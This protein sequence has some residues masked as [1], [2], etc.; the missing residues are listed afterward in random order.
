MKQAFNSIFYSFPSQLTLL[1]FK[2]FQVLLVFWF[3]IFGSV[4]GSFMPMYGINSLYLAPEYL[5]EV[6][7]LSAFIVGVSLGIFIMSWNITTFI[8]FCRHFKFLA[9]TTNPFL[10]YCINNAVIPLAFLVFYF[11]QAVNFGRFKEL[12]SAWEI[13]VLTSGFLC[14]LLLSVLTSLFYFFRADKTINRRMVTRK[15]G[16]ENHNAIDQSYIASSKNGS[17]LIKVKYYFNSPLSIKHVREVGH[18]SSAFIDKV[19][20]RHHFAAVISIFAAFIFLIMIGFSLDRHMFQLPAGASI[21]IFFAIL[22]AVAGAFSYFL[23]SWSV[24]FLVMLFVLLNFLYKYE[25]IDPT[26]KAYGLNYS[27]R[28]HRP[29][30]NRE[31]LMELCSPEHVKKDEEGMLEVLEN[32]RLK[33]NVEKPV[34]YLIA[35]SGGGTRSATFTLNTLQYLDSLCMGKLM[36]KTFMITGSSGGML[37]AAYFRALAQQKSQG[38]DINLSDNKYVDNISGDLL[39]PMLSSFVARDM[40]SPAQKFKAGNYY[41][42]KDR[43][44]AFEQKLAENTQWLLNKQLKDLAADEHQA[45]IPLMLFNSVITQDS[46]RL[47]IS[48][49]PVSFLM[50]PAYDTA[51]VS[52]I[53]PDAVDFGAMFA[54]QDPMDLRLLSALRMNAT[55]PYVLPNVWLPSK[56]VIDVMDAG[57]R[58]NFGQETALRFLF[59]FRKWIAE[60]TSKIV[61]IQIRDR[62]NGGWENP[63]ESADISELITKPMLLLQ[64]NYY[65]TQEYSQNETIS[66]HSIVNTNFYKLSFQYVP[67]KENIGAALNF[68]LTKREKQDIAAALSNENNAREFEKFRLMESRQRRASG[69]F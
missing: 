22:V 9:T 30:Y 13:I 6:N 2:K 45:R 67:R 58:D 56:P 27:N 40:T 10:K 7:F 43:G 46:R 68:H 59:V 69:H 19:F 66:L 44:Y 39:N 41:Y 42:I 25:V 65:K 60:N 47:I 15:Q 64:N 18:Y 37:G 29:S 38:R 35:A 20:S 23:Q 51:R 3:I 33:Q 63:F 57:L 61:L 53:D 8:L 1:H 49:Q 17:R 4:N 34:L 32:W 55:F 5:G 11:F 26:N 62:K 28:K 16:G 36:D 21:T 24:P 54:R 50:R 14:G 12:L 31:A 52:T 48:T